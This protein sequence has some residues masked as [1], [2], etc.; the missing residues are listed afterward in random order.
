M[1]PSLLRVGNFQEQA[2]TKITQKGQIVNRRFAQ[3]IVKMKHG[4][5]EF[6]VENIDQGVSFYFS[7]F[8]GAE[9]KDE[10]SSDQVLVSKD[11]CID[12][13]LMVEFGIVSE[14]SGK[15][16]RTTNTYKYY[17]CPTKEKRI[18]AHVKHEVLKEGTV[19]GIENVDGNY[20]VLGSLKSRSAR[21]KKMVFGDILPYLHVYCKDGN[22][23]EYRM[24]IDP[25]NKEREW[26]ISY[27]DDCDLGSDAW[28]SYDEKEKGKVH[29]VLFSSN[30]DIVKH[31]T[32]ERD[33]IQLRVNEK[34][35]LSIVGTEVDYASIGFGRNSYE[36]GSIHDVNIPSNLVVEFDAE[37]FSSED[38]DYRDVAEEA[39]IYRTI[40]QNRRSDGGFEGSE[41]IYVLTVIP[42]L[43]G[44]LFSWSLLS[45]KFKL[46]PSVEVEL[47]RDNI[48]IS[49]GNVS[50][51]LIG[52]PK[53]KFPKLSP[54]VYTVKV[55]L[56]NSRG[57][58]R[59]IGFD[60]VEL[61]CDQ[62]VNI[63]CTWE[64]NFKVPQIHS[65]GTYICYPVFDSVHNELL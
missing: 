36:K 22:I 6:D 45:N 24:N 7:Y 31:G 63:F 40:A 27:K 3:S 18:Y 52:A 61:K 54:G 13:N 8:H 21:V 51:P 43:T 28:I 38:R 65:S 47:Y 17:Y 55:F 23:R 64:K 58:R 56:N 10:I 62:D 59:F 48:F 16:L 26:I 53:F 14:S 33:G 44:R 19:T 29:A 9:D 50:K 39:K 57:E 34:E 25:E 4:T 20:G 1:E 2:E 37:F 46:L 11:I 15:D 60:Y 30:K 5:E 32:G 49:S 12:G 35:Y 41:N 42:R